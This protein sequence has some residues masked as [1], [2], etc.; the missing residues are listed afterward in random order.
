MKTASSRASRLHSDGMNA[1]IKASTRC[2]DERSDFS[3]RL[4]LYHLSEITVLHETTQ[5][6]LFS[7]LFRLF[8][9]LFTK[10]RKRKL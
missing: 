4:Y 2:F 10:C 8:Q 6:A 3:L 5:K 9:N 1:E 7:G